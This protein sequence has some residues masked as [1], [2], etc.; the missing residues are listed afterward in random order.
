MEIFIIIMGIIIVLGL[1]LF[2]RKKSEVVIEQQPLSEEER[3]RINKANDFN[4]I[5]E[6]IFTIM[7]KGTV[8]TGKIDSGLISIN[9]EADLYGN[10][11]LKRKVTVLGIEMFRKTLD[12]AQADDN[13]GL[14]LGDI[15]K[16]EIE[17]GDTLTLRR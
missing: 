4:M 2:G 12:Y 13:V 6:D 15:S 10:N 16:N 11:G 9:E 7:G 14:L 17:R 3:L 8:V 1:I 5:V